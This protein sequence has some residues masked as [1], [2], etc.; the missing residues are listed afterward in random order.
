MKTLIL[1]LILAMSQLLLIGCTDPGLEV[2]TSDSHIGTV[3]FGCDWSSSSEASKPDSIAIMAVRV[4][5]HY[6]RGM[7]MSTENYR[8]HYFYNA[9]TT[10][11]PWVDPSSI[12]PPPP[13]QTDNNYTIDPTKPNNG[14]DDP[15]TFDPSSEDEAPEILN[16][17]IVVDHFKLPNGTY[18]FYAVG[19]DENMYD[20]VYTNVNEYLQ[21]VGTGMQ[22]SEVEM[23]YNTHQYG[24]EGV[25]Q[26]LGNDYNPGFDIIRTDYPPIFVD[27][28]ELM[29]IADKS[30][31]T[32]TLKPKPLTQN[33]DIWLNIEKDVSDI[34]FTIKKVV[35]EISGIPSKATAFDGH[36]Y[37][38]KTNKMQFTTELTDENGNSIT[39]NSTNTKV[40][41]HANINVLSILH[42][43]KPTDLTG[44]GILQVSV[45]YKYKKPNAAG[46]ATEITQVVSGKMN[47]YNL[48]KQV[49]LI[50]YSSDSQYA[51]KSCDHA[52]LDIPGSM[53]ITPS[54]GLSGGNEGQGGFGNWEQNGD[55]K[56]IDNE[57]PELY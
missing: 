20:H 24:E 11:E 16:T 18:K 31:F 36:L 13:P 37:L 47:L 42:S 2:E 19:V 9:P 30:D 3:R 55:A 46:E 45:T 39:D 25:T 14:G 1:L 54:G 57:D 33:I 4:I 8:G 53:K 26:L 28:V 15:S 23:I 29:E 27:C 34:P 17:S 6:K 22:Y 5:N 56:T 32:I 48:L 44:P 12:T 50:T 21:S 43:S 7:M 35:G 38:S 52:V 10:V 41:I 51:T 40:R 49:N